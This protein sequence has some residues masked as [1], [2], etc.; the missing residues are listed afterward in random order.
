MRKRLTTSPTIY[1][2]F[3]T[4]RFTCFVRATVDKGSL[5][6]ARISW[7]LGTPTIQRSLLVVLQRSLK[8]CTLVL[9]TLYP[10]SLELFAMVKE[11]QR[12][13][14]EYTNFICFDDRQSFFPDIKIGILLYYHSSYITIIIIVT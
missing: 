8:R 4:S 5:T 1:H 6:V 9:F 13:P 7:F 10:V 2:V 3:A 12:F 14:S 11:I